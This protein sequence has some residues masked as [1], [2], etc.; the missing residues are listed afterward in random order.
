[1]EVRKQVKLRQIAS[2]K[3]GAVYGVTIPIEI[4][5][6]Y[7][8]TYFHVSEQDGCILLVSGC[9]PE[10]KKSGGRENQARLVQ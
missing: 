1:M 7:Q 6:S 4:A 8:N 9:L 5:S 10:V 2:G 3:S